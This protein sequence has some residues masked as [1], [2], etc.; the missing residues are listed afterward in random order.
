MT[1]FKVVLLK[2]NLPCGGMG[3]YF[4]WFTPV[5]EVFVISPD[6]NGLIRGSGAEQVGPMTEGTDDGEEFPVVNLVVHFCWCQGFGV[7]ANGAQL[8]RHGRVPLPQDCS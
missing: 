4:L 6:D 5:C 1:E 3:S 7:V 8:L 2:F